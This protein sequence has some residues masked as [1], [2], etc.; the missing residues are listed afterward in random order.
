M[1]AALSTF[2][3]YVRPEVPGCPEIVI[4]DAI[5]RAG[6]EFC[7]RT[8]AIKE[9]VT[10]TTVV[11]QARYA[12]EL[13]EGIEV[14]EVLAVKRAGADNL[15]ASSFDEFTEHH[16]DRDIGTP[17]YY[18]LD[19]NELVLGDIPDAV[20]DLDVI[21]RVRPSENA[22]TLPSELG[23]RYLMEIAA[24]AKSFLMFQRNK[25]W[26]DL[27]GAASNNS[28]FQ[29]AISDANLREAKGGARKPLRT[30]MHSF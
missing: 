5:R 7:K 25:T 13:E 19:G 12:I 30:T 24:G 15:N 18:Y 16:M 8:K 2:A 3:K 9:T 23:N 28:V 14:E 11:D 10:I 26:T 22:T 27:E 29:K 21:V 6:I 17:N 4:Q 1:P 20:E